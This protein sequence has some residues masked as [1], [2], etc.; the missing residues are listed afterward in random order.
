MV[1]AINVLSSELSHAQALRTKDLLKLYHLTPSAT[2]PD[3]HGFLMYMGHSLF[4]AIAAW[5]A[6]DCFLHELGIILSRC[7]NGEPAEAALEWGQEHARL[8]RPVS[9][10]VSKPWTPADLDIDWPMVKRLN[11]V[12]SHPSTDYGLPAN[13]NAKAGASGCI[14]RS[15]KPTTT[16]GL[17]RAA[18]R[19]ACKLYSLQW[20]SV[21]IANLR[22]NS[23]DPGADVNVSFP[24]CPINLRPCISTL[25]RAELVSALGFIA[26]E[27]L[28]LGRFRGAAVG[29]NDEELLEA[30]WTLAREIQA[31]LT[32]S[33]PWREDAVRSVPIVLK[34][35]GAFHAKPTSLQPPCTIGVTGLGVIDG[36]LKT[37]YPISDN[38]ALTVMHVIFHHVTFSYPKPSVLH[39]YSWQGTLYY[40]FG[41]AE[42]F[43]VEKGGGDGPTLV[44]VIDEIERI[45][46]LLAGKDN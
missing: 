39:P 5:Q 12:L 7:S 8:A 30:V 41:F 24:F 18:R 2:A 27:A 34:A 3:A 11:K 46:Y 29:R 35:L 32:E 42:A 23:P 20:A 26:L 22:M 9:D 45:T 37:S 40:S 25:G 1:D 10:R 44:D 19:H 21:L 28:D 16:E 43:V 14:V 36:L 38:Q 15:F 4:D 31:Q 6:L 17:I 13:Y 33:E